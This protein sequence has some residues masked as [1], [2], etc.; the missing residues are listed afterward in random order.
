MSRTRIRRPRT[1][2]SMP[3]AKKLP[4]AARDR[5]DSNL[6]GKRMKT[7]RP[8]PGPKTGRRI[9]KEKLS[10]R[11]QEISF[12]YS[13]VSVGLFVSIR[14]AF[15]RFRLG[16]RSSGSRSAQSLR[17]E[18]YIASAV[19]TSLRG[20]YLRRS[21]ASGSV[22]VGRRGARGRK[23]VARLVQAIL[24]GLVGGFLRDFLGG[25]LGGF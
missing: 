13:I 7:A 6:G 25:F 23:P 3:I 8:S 11:R 20:E 4:S 19:P 21:G 2:Y 17:Q 16:R 12:Y 18:N 22:F 9:A 5:A 10:E 14:D 1:P 24:R 15:L